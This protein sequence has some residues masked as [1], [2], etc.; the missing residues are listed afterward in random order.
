MIYSDMDIHFRHMILFQVWFS[1]LH[2]IAGIHHQYNEI[3]WFAV[4]FG[5]IARVMQ[6]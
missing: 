6:N 4:V 3:S 1:F 2:A 5:L